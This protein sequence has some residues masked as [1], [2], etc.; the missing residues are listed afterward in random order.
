MVNIIVQL[1]QCLLKY[2]LCQYSDLGW[3]FDLHINFSLLPS[4]PATVFYLSLSLCPS[5]L[6]VEGQA[7]NI[8]TFLSKLC[9]INVFFN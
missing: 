6:G 2:C 1:K 7:G 9:N 3:Q 5:P 4:L 8:V